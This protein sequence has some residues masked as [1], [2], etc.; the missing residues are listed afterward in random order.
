MLP[1]DDVDPV[2]A[3]D[4]IDEELIT[5]PEE[6]ALT[7]EEEPALLDVAIPELAP[8]LE[9]DMKKALVEDEL[10]EAPDGDAPKAKTHQVPQHYI[11]QELTWEDLIDKNSI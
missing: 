4:E 5:T 3:D 8:E 11:D 7:A 1:I 6:G 9:A 10:E 2:V